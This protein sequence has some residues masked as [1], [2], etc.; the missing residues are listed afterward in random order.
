MAASGSFFWRGKT[1][2][3]APFYWREQPLDAVRASLHT[4]I[5]KTGEIEVLASREAS[6][7]NRKKKLARFSEL[8]IFCCFLRDF[9]QKMAN[10]E[11][12]LL[13]A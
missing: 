3:I 7:T 2:T 5:F 10:F 6:F 9:L 4:D 8:A 1:E 13:S 12:A 11:I